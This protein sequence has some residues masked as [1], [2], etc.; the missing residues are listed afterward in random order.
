MSWGNVK[1]ESTLDIAA[2]LGREDRLKLTTP[3]HKGNENE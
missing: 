2:R 1:E 3:Q